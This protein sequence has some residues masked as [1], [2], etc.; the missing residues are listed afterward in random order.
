MELIKDT[1]AEFV[2][3][4]KE[5]IKSL[6]KNLFSNYNILDHEFSKCIHGNFYVKISF[7]RN[8]RL[9]LYKKISFIIKNKISYLFLKISKILKLKRL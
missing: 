3:D 2:F 8:K 7:P 9:F 5:N 4:D 6:I 1:D